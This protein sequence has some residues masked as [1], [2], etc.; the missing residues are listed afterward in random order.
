MM[1]R[2]AHQGKNLVAIEGLL[3]SADRG[4]RRAAGVQVDLGR[5]GTIGIE[6]ALGVAQQRE[7]LGGV[8]AQQRL[9]VLEHLGVRARLGQ[10][11][12][13][14]ARQEVL[15]GAEDAEGSLDMAGD[16]V[17]G[18]GGIVQDKHRVFLGKLGLRT[19]TKIAARRTRLLQSE[20]DGKISP[21]ETAGK[22]GVRRIRMEKSFRSTVA[23]RCTMQLE[24]ILTKQ[25][26]AIPVLCCA[27]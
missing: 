16:S 10:I 20:A 22:T 24:Q 23:N 3:G 17:G 14:M 15:G 1:P 26:L 6:I 12:L 21:R 8:R 4:V 7:V 27:K 11:P 5:R 19:W 25:S 18:A 9:V 13:R 2:R